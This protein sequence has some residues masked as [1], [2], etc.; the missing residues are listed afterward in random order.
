MKYSRELLVNHAED[1]PKWFFADPV[2]WNMAA[3]IG[4]GALEV[5]SVEEIARYTLRP[6]AGSRPIPIREN[7]KEV[8][9]FRSRVQNDGSIHPTLITPANKMNGMIKLLGQR[10]GYRDDITP[11][12]FRRTFGNTIDS[13]L[14]H[15][16]QYSSRT[17]KGSRTHHDC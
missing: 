2:L 14:R 16:G 4:D 7:K 17:D 12:A 15:H 6:T 5:R 9:L 3:A 10:Y 13:K 1:N 11:Y 8:P